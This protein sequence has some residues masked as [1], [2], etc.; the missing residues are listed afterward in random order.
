M[1]DNHPKFS[2]VVIG[3][4]FSG[5]FKRICKVNPLF[6]IALF[7]IHYISFFNLSLLVKNFV[8]KERF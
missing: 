1:L 4:G 8:I 3:A 2:N 6:I 7:S 5:M